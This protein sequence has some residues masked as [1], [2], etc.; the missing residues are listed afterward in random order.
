MK[1]KKG[2]LFVMHGVGSSLLRYSFDDEREEVTETCPSCGGSYVT[3]YEPEHG[4]VDPTL[5]HEPDCP[6]LMLVV[7]FENQAGVM[8]VN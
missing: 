2:R 7:S 5:E 8:N 4:Q 1:K 3:P 6:V